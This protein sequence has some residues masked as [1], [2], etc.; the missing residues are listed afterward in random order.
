MQMEEVMSHTFLP[1]TV[2]DMELTLLKVLQWSLACV[3]P[4]SFLHL[5]LP[6]L[7][8]TPPPPLHTTTAAAA[9]AWT[10]TRC[11]RLLIRSLAGNIYNN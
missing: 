6:L 9:A 5:L 8:I 3:T 1:A 4:Y 7:M 11:T 10:T 2:L